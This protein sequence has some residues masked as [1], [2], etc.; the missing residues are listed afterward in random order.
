M[1][2]TQ[3]WNRPQL[4]KKGGGIQSF[5]QAEKGHDGCSCPE[6]FLRKNERKLKKSPSSYLL[7]G[8]KTGKKLGRGKNSLSR[9]SRKGKKKEVLG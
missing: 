4:I 8:K 9:T 6:T 3:K 1:V 2:N 7:R 5:F